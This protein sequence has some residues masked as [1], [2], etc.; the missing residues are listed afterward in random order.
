MSIDTCLTITIPGTTAALL[1][2]SPSIPHTRQVV[3]HIN[4]KAMQLK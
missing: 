1:G 4:S 2:E 3:D